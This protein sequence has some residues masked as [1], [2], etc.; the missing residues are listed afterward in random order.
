MSLFKRRKRDAKPI[1]AVA[2][3]EAHQAEV[4]SRG[5]ADLQDAARPLAP[6]AKAFMW[7]LLVVGMMFM[8]LLAWRAF[9]VKKE[10]DPDAVAA[11]RAEIRNVLPSLKLKTPEPESAQP[12]PTPPE[13]AAPPSTVSTPSM[14]MAPGA[15]AVAVVPALDPV[16]Q[17]RLASGLQGEQDKGKQDP[18]R[19]TPVKTADS[20]PMADKLQPLKLSAARAGRIGNRDMLITQGAMIDCGLDTKLVSAQAGMISCYATRD[21]RSTSGRVVLIDQGTKFTGYQQNVIA[22][23]QPRIGVVWSRLE[24]PEGVI[25]SLDSPGTGSLG[26]AGLDG[27]IDTHFAERFGGAILVSLIGDLGAWAS[28]RGGDR[29]G[30][31]VR[32]DNTG[33]AAK[34]AVTTVLDHTIN[35][36]P[37]LYRNQGGRVGIYVARDLDFSGVY[38]LRPVRRSGHR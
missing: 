34:D 21:V 35:I 29:N 23:G 36:P 3:F 14:L 27:Y 16:E 17:R 24:T 2:E 33:N 31:T 30:G 15:A 26:E 6:G 1:D 28:N 18:A 19:S 4:S 13:P 32:F 25:V 10:K 9:S 5:R 7:L 11:L 22:Q 37:T 20:G 8:G 12:P 38:D